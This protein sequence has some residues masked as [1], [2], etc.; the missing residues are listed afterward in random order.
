VLK[1]RAC[2]LQLLKK[3]NSVIFGLV[4]SV[5][6]Q[7]RQPHLYAGDRPLYS[8]VCVQNTTPAM[9]DTLVTIVMFSYL[10]FRPKSYYSDETLLVFSN[11]N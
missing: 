1:S 7:E 2:G 9:I 11:F 5:K 6:F 3:E 10:L 8:S 4:H